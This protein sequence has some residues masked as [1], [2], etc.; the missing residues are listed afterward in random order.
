MHLSIPP[1]RV[2][3][4]LY[5]QE[6]RAWKT[7]K[8][9]SSQSSKSEQNQSLTRTKGSRNG[10]RST[11]S[12]SV[13]GSGSVLGEPGVG[14]SHGNVRNQMH[15]CFCLWLYFSP[16][17]ID[18]NHLP[19]QIWSASFKAFQRNPGKSHLPSDTLFSLRQEGTKETLSIG[20]SGA[21]TGVNLFT[22]KIPLTDLPGSKESDAM[23][24]P[25]EIWG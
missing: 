21:N 13:A 22:F 17:L 12:A 15:L 1:Y 11:Q 23:Q 25:Q 8:D 2:Q 18:R 6:S 7:L 24:V 9:F 10:P 20:S 5:K 16:F 4:A 19:L 14:I 3:A